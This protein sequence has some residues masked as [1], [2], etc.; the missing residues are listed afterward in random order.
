MNM[1]PPTELRLSIDWELWL[2]EQLLFTAKLHDL[3]DVLVAHG[4]APA[5]ARARVAE[6]VDSPAFARL[7]RRLG[8]ARLAANLQRLQQQL[9]RQVT[10]PVYDDL[11]P[12]RL[13][14]DHWVASRPALLTRTAAQIPAVRTWS[15]AW[16]AT[17]FGS[18]PV[19]VNCERL[20]ASKV[21]QTEHRSRVMPLGQLIDAIAT[22]PSNDFYLVSRNGLLARPE[23]A[24]VWT[25]FCD[26][27]AFLTP[28]QPP[29]GVSLWLGP[30]GTITPP[31]FDPHNV[32]LVQ[33]QGRKRIRLASRLRADMFPELDGYYLARPLDEVFAD[34]PEAVAEVTLEPGQALFVPVAWFHE[35]TALS[36]SMTLSF[37][38]FQWPNDFHWIGPHGSDDHEHDS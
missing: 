17:R 21:S 14:A 9:C 28:L 29:R 18:L 16:L 2:I 34:R 4:L 26:L 12:E 13:Y 23:L 31:H 35:V 19:E 24:A 36:P 8:E 3:V 33:V 38:N 7:A 25:D 11:S 6:V 32:L 10:I 37:L 27:P 30:A 20:R 15:L 5:T 22:G 1:Q